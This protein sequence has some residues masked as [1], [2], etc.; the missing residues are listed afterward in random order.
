[1]I[2]QTR[3]SLSP[4]CTRPATP[5]PSVQP[6]RVFVHWSSRLFAPSF[7]LLPIALIHNSNHQRSNARTILKL[8]SEPRPSSDP[9]STVFLLPLAQLPSLF[10]KWQVAGRGSAYY[11]AF[12]DS[13]AHRFCCS[14]TTLLNSQ[15]LS[16]KTLPSTSSLPRGRPLVPSTVPCHRFPP[17][18]WESPPSSMP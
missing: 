3:R 17:L 8:C 1:M 11:L 6:Q 12:V 13:P 4:F 10:A 14:L 18:N 7:H 15:A 5:K 2:L 16:L 9:P